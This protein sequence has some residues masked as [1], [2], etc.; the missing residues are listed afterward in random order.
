V[1]HEDS[2]T[3]GVGAEVAAFIAEELFE[4]L[5]GPILRVAALDTPVPWAPQLEE[6]V[7]PGTRHILDAVRR[8][9]A[10]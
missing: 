3:A 8:L 5:D 7:I 6:A 4:D 1:C 9:A 2:K 10:Y